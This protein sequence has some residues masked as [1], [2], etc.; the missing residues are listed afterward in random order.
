M[1]VHEHFDPNVGV[2][3]ETFVFLAIS[4]ALGVIHLIEGLDFKIRT[5]YDITG[6][7]GL[8]S[9]HIYILCAYV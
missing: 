6:S 9:M 1:D 4:R 7:G 8:V 3:H 2:G 5:F